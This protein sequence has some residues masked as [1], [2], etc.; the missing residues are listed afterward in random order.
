MRIMHRDLKSAN[1]FL[2]SDGTVK[3]GDL[4]VSK[5]M[6]GN[7]QFTQTGTPYYASP[8]VWKDQPYNSKS[9]IWSLGWVIYE[10]IC[11]K[12]PFEA[13][14]MDKLFK[15]VIKGNFEPLPLNYSNGLERIVRSW[16]KVVPSKRPSWRLILNDKWTRKWH[17]KITESQ[18]PSKNTIK[19]HSTLNAKEK[20]ANFNKNW[21]LKIP[22]NFNEPEKLK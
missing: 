6:K 8:E 9:D 16:I 21:K 1:I 5:V 18:K 12:P 2:F 22:Q 10:L 11:Q 13:R 20:R 14:S 17:R 15:M 19:S 3:L 4:N 7:M